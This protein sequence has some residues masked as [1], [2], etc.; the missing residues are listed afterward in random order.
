MVGR[1]RPVRGGSAGAAQPPAGDELRQHGQHQH[2]P[3]T[4]LAAG[5]GRLLGALHPLQL[6]PD[7]RQLG[8]RVPLQ[9][10]QRLE[11]LLQ[12]TDTETNTQSAVSLCSCSS[13]WRH[14]CSLQ[15]QTNT[16]SAVSLCSC[17]SGWRHFCSLQADR[18]SVSEHWKCL[19]SHTC[20]INMYA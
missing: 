13:G 6:P 3:R 12:P 16:Q 14:F 10:L 18:R 9:L 1:R 11:T 4:E 2:Q 15:T 20:R 5:A 7:G 19:H 8:G 17:S